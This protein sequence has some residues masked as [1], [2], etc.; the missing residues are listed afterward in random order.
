M[1]MHGRAINGCARFL[2]LWDHLQIF[3]RQ[4]DH[5]ASFVGWSA[6]LDF[7][8]QFFARKISAR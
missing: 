3:P 5:L 7:A 8:K 4:Y 1:E 6:V 2:I